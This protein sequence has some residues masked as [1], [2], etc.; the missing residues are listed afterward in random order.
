MT[1]GGHFTQGSNCISSEKSRSNRN[2]LRV[3]LA[4]ISTEMTADIT[5]S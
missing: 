4:S 5:I 1:P 2:V 3:L